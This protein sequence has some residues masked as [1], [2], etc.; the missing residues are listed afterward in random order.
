MIQ[1][2]LTVVAPGRLTRS[3]AARMAQVADVESAGSA[4][5]YRVT[6]QSIRRALDTGATAAD[7]HELFATPFADR[8]PAGAG[9]TWSTTSPPARAAAGR[10]GTA[11]LRSDDP[12]VIDQAIARGDGRG[13][14]PAPAGAD[15]RGVDRQASRT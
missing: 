3:L 8:R 12:A 5:V 11:Y 9:P 13:G 4:T 10:H 6:Q 2:D 1:A 14:A 7:L 15:G